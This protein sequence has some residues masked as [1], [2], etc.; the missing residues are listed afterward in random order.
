[1][2]V[3]SLLINVLATETILIITKIIFKD[4]D[5]FSGSNKQ[6]FTKLF[7]LAGQD[8]VLFNNKLFKQIDCEAMGITLGPLF[9]N[10]FLGYLEQQ[11]FK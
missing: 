10:F 3:E 6:T 7:C 5:S 9:A 8:N 4:I 1:M 11:Y 2:D